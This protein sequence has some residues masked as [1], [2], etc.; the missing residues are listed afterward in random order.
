MIDLRFPD[1]FRAGGYRETTDEAR[2]KS[3]T[4]PASMRFEVGALET[5]PDRLVLP[6]VL[7]NE[8]ASPGEIVVV[9]GVFALYF[10]HGAPVRMRPFEGPPRP[11]PAPPPPMILE[12]PAECRVLLNAELYLPDWIYEGTPRVLL[13]WTF[14]VWNPPY[15]RGELHVTL[16]T[17]SWTVN[18]R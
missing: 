4:F 14:Q 3:A 13:E 7:T 5:R 12:V 16:P 15:P 8:S 9:L 6:G 1:D 18:D 11:A 17:T 2:M 10:A